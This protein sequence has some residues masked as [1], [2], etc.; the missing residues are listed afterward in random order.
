[1][2]TQKPLYD[3]KRHINKYLSLKVFSYLIIY[4][5][6]VKF[7]LYSISDSK[8]TTF[9]TISDC[10]YTT[11]YAISDCKYTTAVNTTAKSITLLTL[12]QFL[13]CFI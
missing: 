11:F 13:I 6:A 9:Y 12:F 10:K 4:Q 5:S 1:M 2:N 8:Y 7:L 3:N